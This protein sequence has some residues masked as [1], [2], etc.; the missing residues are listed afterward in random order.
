MNGL[1]T[2]V[3]IRNGM[4]KFVFEFQRRMSTREV[5]KWKEHLQRKQLLLQ[6]HSA[7]DDQI[8]LETL[9]VNEYGTGGSLFCT[10]EGMFQL[11]GYAFGA[12]DSPEDL[13]DK[14][15]K[16]L[17]M[18]DCVQKCLARALAGIGGDLAKCA[19]KEKV[20]SRSAQLKL[21]A[22]SRGTRDGS[23]SVSLRFER[24]LSAPTCMFATLPPAADKVASVLVVDYIYG[25]WYE[26]NE[27]KV[28]TIEPAKIMVT[29]GMWPF[30]K[31]FEADVSYVV[32][33]SFR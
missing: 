29:T 9:K 15:V 6:L 31:V 8:D 13:S 22:N 23:I 10:Q 1:D 19:G 17:A 18:V 11:D 3:Q 5:Q 7:G 20:A 25:R 4:R 21:R 14:P 27:S 32:T 12:W 28:L 16:P 2:N 26:E 24:I 30:F 33:E